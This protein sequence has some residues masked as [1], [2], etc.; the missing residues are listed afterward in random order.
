MLQTSPGHLQ[1]WIHVSTLP[2]Q[3]TVAT[4]IGKHW[5]CVYGGDSASTDW[6]HLGRLAG[7]TNQ[8]SERRTG[9]GYAPWVK[10]VQARAGLA[11]GGEAAKAKE[12][13]LPTSPV[14]V[15]S[16][17]DI[18]FGATRP[19]LAPTGRCRSLSASVSGL[20]S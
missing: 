5:A 7:F 4:A 1:A 3:P 18:T 9:N 11:R 19:T 14:S 17:I 20:V 16:S 13:L 10:I 6:R 8:K 15:G 2:L 12:A